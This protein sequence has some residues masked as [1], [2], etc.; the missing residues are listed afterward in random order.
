MTTQMFFTLIV[1]VGGLA[2][3]TYG[4]WV[5]KHGQIT[6][7]RGTRTET[8]TGRAAQRIGILIVIGAIS[9]TLVDLLVVRPLL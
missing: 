6:L 4:L 2:G 8:Y 9:I 5:L 3:I 1:S 7:R